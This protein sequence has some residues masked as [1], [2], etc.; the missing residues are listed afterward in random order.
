M[1]EDGQ[2]ADRCGELLPDGGC[3]I[4]CDRGFVDSGMESGRRNKTVLERTYGKNR[5]PKR[6]NRGRAKYH[7]FYV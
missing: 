7:F 4:K 2:P 1:D 6:R 3:D 5:F